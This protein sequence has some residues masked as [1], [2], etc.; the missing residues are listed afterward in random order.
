MENVIPLNSMIQISILLAWVLGTN[1]F[2]KLYELFV[3]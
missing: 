2:Y 1:R 3:K